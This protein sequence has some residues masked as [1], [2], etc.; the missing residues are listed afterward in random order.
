MYLNDSVAGKMDY[1]LRYRTSVSAVTCRQKGA[2][3]LRASMA[4]EST[5]P[6]SFQ[7]LGPYV[8][9]TGEFAPQGTIAVNLRI[10]APAGGEIT[11]LK[12]DGETRSITSD[13]HRGRPVAF[14]PI[15]LKPG[16]QSVVTA[17]IRTAP[18]QDDDGVFSFTPGMV[19][20]P[21]GV[22][23]TSACD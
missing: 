2:Q 15:S 23:I 19:S 6:T 18:G 4:L 3:D 20:A 21:N 10:Y 8:L 7:G 11:G 17:D 9:G 1:Y 5:M 22:T 16:Q 13:L 14:V 12:V